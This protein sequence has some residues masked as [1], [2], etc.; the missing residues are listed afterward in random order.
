MWA[1]RKLR[2]SSTVGT[3]RLAVHL[4]TCRLARTE[5]GGALGG[6]LPDRIYTI[7]VSDEVARRQPLDEHNL[8]RRSEQ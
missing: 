8:R 4:G 2:P 1:L 3:P 7:G 5:S 6:E